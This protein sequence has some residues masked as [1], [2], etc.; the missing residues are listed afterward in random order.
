MFRRSA[1][2]LP[3][4]DFILCRS[5]AAGTW[6]PRVYV[7]AVYE[8]CRCLYEHASSCAPVSCSVVRFDAF[9]SAAFAEYTPP[10][11]D[12]HTRSSSAFC[13]GVSTP[14]VCPA[15]RLRCERFRIHQRFSANSTPFALPVCCFPRGTAAAPDSRFLLATPRGLPYARRQ[16]TSYAAVL[17]RFLCYVFCVV[18]WCLVTQ[19]RFILALPCLAFVPASFPRG[20]AFLPLRQ[21]FSCLRHWCVSCTLFVTAVTVRHQTPRFERGMYA[22]RTYKTVPLLFCTVWRSPYCVAC[23]TNYARTT[24]ADHRFCLFLLTCRRLPDH[25]CRSAGRRDTL[26]TFAYRYTNT[27]RSTSTLPTPSN[28]ADRTRLLVL[29]CRFYL[30]C[31]MGVYVVVI[32]LYVFVP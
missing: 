30:F 1:L 31:A 4:F 26:T 28:A 3:A 14:R 29:R 11:L 9:T 2:Y 27:M 6:A 20:W 17:L 16:V 8:L 15:E 7:S 24:I 5:F 21:R 10:A 13:Y 23:R 22:I 25:T 32:F 18:S 12:A 19:H